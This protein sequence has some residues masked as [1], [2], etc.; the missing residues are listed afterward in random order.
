MQSKAKSDESKNKTNKQQKMEN[1]TKKNNE[2]CEES[3]HAT[4]Q[5]YVIAKEESCP[6]MEL[7]ILK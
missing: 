2:R 7:Y 4:M 6:K 1:K 3:S 5:T